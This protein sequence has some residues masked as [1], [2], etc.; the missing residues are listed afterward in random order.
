VTDRHTGIDAVRVLLEAGADPNFQLKRRVPFRS[1]GPDRGCDQLLVQGATPL[2]RAAKTHEVEAVALLLEHGAIVDL[3]QLVGIT[4]L[5]AAAGGGSWDCDP[6][7]GANA[8]RSTDN[9][10]ASFLANGGG[11]AMEQRAIRVIDLLLDA[12]ADINA[13][14]WGPHGH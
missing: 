11:Y 3:P 5:M 4:P 8:G 10:D 9:P 12:G 7:G 13:R 6:R 14:M 1:V 2:I